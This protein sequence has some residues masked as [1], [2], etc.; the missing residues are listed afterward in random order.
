MIISTD[1]SQIVSPIFRPET[2]N[3]LI[4]FIYYLEFLYYKKFRWIIYK[5][6]FFICILYSCILVWSQLTPIWIGFFPNFGQNFSIFYLIT[7]LLSKI[8]IFH[9]FFLQLFSL[10]TLGLVT[11][12]CYFSL[13]SLKLP[14]R[15][16]M[17]P[18]VTDESSLIY[19]SG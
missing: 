15:M 18:F 17:V 14:S 7:N 6:A 1:S 5:V 11:V 9:R 8:P 4:N 3:K 12:L 10:V 13:F 2:E 19:L 16:T